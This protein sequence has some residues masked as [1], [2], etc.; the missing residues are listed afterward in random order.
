LG[1]ATRQKKRFENKNLHYIR[2]AEI[3]AEENGHFLTE[4]K[5][6]FNN[7]PEKWKQHRVINSESS[8]A[9]AAGITT[10]IEVSP[11]PNVYLNSSHRRIAND[12]IRDNINYYHKKAG[13]IQAKI[14]VQLIS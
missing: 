9:I 4:N 13:T 11:V 5:I 1:G 2:N 14:P 6:R 7:S 10:R 8:E 3:F 12:A